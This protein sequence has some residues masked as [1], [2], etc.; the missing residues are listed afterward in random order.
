MANKLAIIIPAYKDA[1]FNKTLESLA[2]QT[3]KN[4]TVYIGD[5]NSPYN[6]EK[7]VSEYSN[8]LN[9]IYKRFPT[10]LGSTDLVLQWNRCLSM[11][12]DE[13]FFC[14]FSDDDIM[15]PT[16]VENF[17]KSLQTNGDFDIFHF[18][19]NLINAKGE[20]TSECPPYPSVLSADNFLY[21]LYTNR[22]DARMPEFIFKTQHFYAS[23]G[24][25]NFDLAY[26]SDNAT[27]IASAKDKGIYTIPFSKILWRNSGVNVSA[28]PDT[29]LKIRRTYASIAF[30]NWLEDYYKQRKEPCP[31]HTKRRLKLIISDILTLTDCTSQKELYRALKQ[32]NS[33]KHNYLQYLR[34]KLYMINKI[35]KQKK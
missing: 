29:Q 3:N 5:D 33:I 14:L 9:I 4:F 1:F 8:Q 31:L 27:V 10:N 32:S 17:Y 7:I 11:I 6:L 16:C 2:Q 30:F 26:R 23:G 22:I 15:E 35:R 19:I 13:D 18:D 20:V 28:N 12:Q 34:W 25:I 24:F 21:M